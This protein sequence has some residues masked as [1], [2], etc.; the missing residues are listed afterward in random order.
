MMNGLSVSWTA[1]K[2]AKSM[3]GSVDGLRCQEKAR[4]TRVT[5][6]S[7]K[8]GVWRRDCTERAQ[9]FLSPKRPTIYV[10]LTF[11]QTQQ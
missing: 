8:R 10:V 11:Q 1:G 7:G 5:A 3:T 4:R 6:C 9:E 2:T